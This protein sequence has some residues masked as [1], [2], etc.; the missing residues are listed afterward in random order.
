[1]SRTSASVVGKDCLNLKTLYSEGAWMNRARVAI[2]GSGNIG[3][4]LM[5]KVVRHDS[6]SLVLFA[7]IDPHSKGLQRAREMGYDVSVHGIEGVL[8]AGA[9]LV[10][11]ATSAGAHLAHAPRL[12]EAGILCVDLTPAAVGPPIVPVVNLDDLVEAPNV[13]LVSCGGQATIPIVH[14]IASVATVNYA[15]VVCTIASKSAGPGTRQNID[16]F[17]RTTA[18]GLRIVGGSPIGKAIIILNPADPPI[19]M[20][21]SVHLMVQD[22]D[23]D[24]IRTAVIQMVHRVAEYVPGY[25][26]RVEPIAEGN[27]VTTILEVEG[28]GDFLP[29]YAGNLD[30]ITS[31]ATEVGARLFAAR[32]RRAA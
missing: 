13:S 1:M 15:E 3:T 30:I 16:E 25:R 31:A 5:M 27:R 4:D 22:V 11:D 32:Q 10:F 29:A 24:A 12:A 17:T 18:A 26:L 21:N 9:D 20:T 14:A 7:G 28:A 19:I 6:L 8:E 23:M 2:L